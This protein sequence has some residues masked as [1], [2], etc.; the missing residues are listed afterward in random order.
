MAHSQILAVIPARGGS[1]GVPR[2]NI[3][4]LAGKPLI[5]WTI[6]VAL[7]VSELFARVL[8][9]TDDEEVAA[10][11]REHGA[12]VPFLRPPELS[13]DTT[14]MLPV[15]QHA[16]EIA[17]RESDSRFEWIMLLQPTAPLRTAD[18]IRNAVLASKEGYCDSVISVVRVFAVHPILMKRI[19]NGWLVPFC[20][21][22]HEGTRRQD[23]TP[24]AY[25]RNGAIY[26]PRREVVMERKSIWGRQ[27]RPYV[28]PE[29]RSP[30]IDDEIDFQLCDLLMSKRLGCTPQ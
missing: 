9:S 27:I 25:M 28:M 19:D 30:S 17:E 11:A 13:G 14:P 23:Y 2:K 26:L 15:V 12:D 8:V 21:E 10:I 4:A 24:P 5:A 22:E 3:R 20:I 29:E 7:E 16:V 18:D 6:Q 1:K